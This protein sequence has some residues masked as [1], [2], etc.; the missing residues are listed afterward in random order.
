ML[1]SS[2]LKLGYQTCFQCSL[3]VFPSL[4]KFLDNT[5]QTY[6]KKKKRTYFS[7]VYLPHSNPINQET[8]AERFRGDLLA[9]ITRSPALNF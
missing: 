5:E 4:N 7:K 1:F 2:R 8:N 9:I 3:I 6:S